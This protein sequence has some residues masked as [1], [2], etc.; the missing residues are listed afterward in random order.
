MHILGVDAAWTAGEPTGVAV[1]SQSAK[2]W[3]CQGV[4]PSYASFI[5]LTEG[6]PVSWAIKP[7]GEHP[8]SPDLVDAAAVLV[9]GSIDVVAVDMPVST[10]RFSSRRAADNAISQRFGAA[11]C[12]AHSPSATRP[13]QVGRAFSEELSSSHRLVTDQREMGV[14]PALIEVYPHPALLTLLKVS[15]R[16]PYKASKTGKYWVGKDLASRGQLLLEQWHLILE[17]L[18]REIAGIDLP[19]PT[20]FTPGMTIAGL[21][22]YEDALD[23]LIC[24]WVGIRYLKGRCDVFGDDTAAIWVPH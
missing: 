19:I 16:V 7:S 2:G 24:A 20:T 6:E 8:R 4:A 22:R 18:N 14:I 17:A 23:A 13:G 12:S 9:G 15:Q 11:W 3:N 1:V 21:K 10:E 5:A